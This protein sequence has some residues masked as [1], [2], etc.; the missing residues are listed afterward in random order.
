MQVLSN[1][2]KDKEQDELTAKELKDVA[3]VLVDP[4]LI[5]SKDKD[6]RLLI[7]CC[8]ADIIRLFAPN[9]PYSEDELKVC[10][11]QKKSR[12]DAHD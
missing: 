6:V 10:D 2:L 9:A 7:A 12:C 5:N 3:A 1:T 4:T 11:T 8:L